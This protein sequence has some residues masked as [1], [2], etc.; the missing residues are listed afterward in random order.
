MKRRFLAWLLCA[1]MLFNNALPVFA[2]EATEHVHSEECGHV[3]CETCGLYDCEGHT[4]CTICGAL[5]CEK[6]HV[7][8]S[9]C[10]EYD[11]VKEHK[12]CEICSTVDCTADHAYCEACEKYDCGETHQAEPTTC[13]DCDAEL[14]EGET[15]T[16]PP[17]CNCGETHDETN[18]DCPLYVAPKTHKEGCTLDADHEGDC[19]VAPANTCLDCKA[20]IAE[21]EEHE[22]ELVGPPKCCDY[23]EV[24][25]NG[26]PVHVGNCPNITPCG[27]CGQLGHDEN[28]CH[29]CLAC[30]EKA[31]EH[32][33]DA[34]CTYKCEICGEKHENCPECKSC[35]NVEG[36]AHTFGE[37]CKACPACEGVE[38]AEHKTGC[39]NAPVLCELCGSKVK[40]VHNEMCP[41]LC[42]CEAEEGAEHAETC[43]LYVEKKW[44]S[45]DYNAETFEHATDC[46][47]CLGCR[48]ESEE[49]SADKNCKFKCLGCGNIILDAEADHK[50]D[51]VFCIANI[52]EPVEET[53][54]D[55][56]DYTCPS[57]FINAA[58]LIPRPKRE[59]ATFN[60]LKGNAPKDNENVITTKTVTN[61][62]NGQ[63]TLTLESYIE[64]KTSTEN[65]P[66][67]VVLVLD[68]S[69]SMRSCYECGIVACK[70]N[71]LGQMIVSSVNN[72]S[73]K[74]EYHMWTIV[75]RNG[76]NASGIPTYANTNL[77]DRY[78]YNEGF[79]KSG[80]SLENK[81]KNDGTVYYFYNPYGAEGYG[82]VYL[83]NYCTKCNNWVKYKEHIQGV[84]A[85]QC[86]GGQL[87][88]GTTSEDGYWGTFM[89]Y[90]PDER[91][92][93]PR[94]DALK[95]AVNEF[96]GKV[97]ED[98]QDR[99][100]ENNVAIVGFAAETINTGVIAPLGRLYTEDE[101]DNFIIQMENLEAKGITRT[102]LGMKEASKILNSN[103]IKY[104][105][106]NKVVIVF[107]DGEPTIESNGP[108][109]IAPGDQ[110]VS[111]FNKYTANNALAEAQT[112]KRYATI[113]TIGIFSGD[114]GDREK[115]LPEYNDWTWDQYVGQNDARQDATN[116]FC[117]LLSSNYL[118][119]TDMINTGEENPSLEES[120]AGYFISPDD[121]ETLVDA[122]NRIAN[123]LQEDASLAK[124]DSTTKVTDIVSP[125]F[126]VDVDAV[127]TREITAHTESYTE[128][129]WIDNDDEG[130]FTDYIVQSGN[131]ISVSNFNFY[132]NRVG[133]ETTTDIG[134]TITKRYFGK[135]LVIEIPIKVK[136]DFL[137]GNGVLTNDFA[138]GI[139]TS[140]G[141][142]IENFE[143][144]TVNI[145]VKE[146]V[147]TF[148]TGNIY[149][150]QYA[151]VSHIANVGHFSYSDDGETVYTTVDGINNAYVDIEY[152]ITDSEGNSIIYLLEDKTSHSDHGIDNWVRGVGNLDM[153]PFLTGDTTYKVKAVV[154]PI[155][156]TS[157]A[158]G[159]NDPI[160]VANPSDEIEKQILVYKPHITF[161]DSAMDL[162]ETADYATNNQVINN[163]EDDA[164]YGTNIVWKNGSDLA[165]PT[166]MGPAPILTYTYDPVAADFRAET[167]VK[168]TEIY[169][170]AANG[171]DGNYGHDVKEDENLLPYVTFYREA[172]EFKGCGHSD[173][174][175]F[176]SSSD[177]PNF[178]VHLNPFD[179][180]IKKN[181]ADPIDE[182]QSF[183][184]RVEGNGM[185][186]DVIVQGN[187]SA[188]VVSLPVGD[189]EY[190]VT[191]LIDWSWRYEVANSGSVTQ[192]VDLRNYKAADGP[193]TI[194]FNNTR[195]NILWLD[196][197]C[198][199]ENLW[200]GTSSISKKEEY[201]DPTKS[202]NQ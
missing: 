52:E 11:C 28:N 5:D 107:T 186:L 139:Y 137:G 154:T 119:A 153:N 22:C 200:T 46:Q 89:A 27:T 155:H 110:I 158:A 31:D 198:Y 127:N 14:V 84:T 193:A 43:P 171:Y 187:N 104:N 181:G 24:D 21:G 138:S 74:K 174:A 7:K 170:A 78:N 163:T 42:N 58:G 101:L 3:P 82:D 195:N 156:V 125:S 151:T 199:C 26:M 38:D 190:T 32:T 102:D 53:Q 182:N 39:E 69:G 180:I 47:E 113:Y 112:I 41:T 185:V 164:G 118:K 106:H 152:T 121:Y 168:V 90:D 77:K 18:A 36:E 169:A 184:F 13:P 94:R 16:C 30:L 35:W 62:G 167:P 131:E 50:E 143:Q 117:H 159:N 144:P 17:S 126:I 122:F 91:N 160:Y 56:M 100:V 51:C 123:N 175:P 67:D 9:I 12:E 88:T 120:D 10:N 63:Y 116:R 66:V 162:G 59:K 29:A 6:E 189:G 97:L 114:E 8:C 65:L 145:P 64:A 178:Y 71:A 135:K 105:N 192:N 183:I 55:D 72:S 2:T 33:F 57:G 157:D 176:T 173:E 109:P 44:C 172:C 194:T 34:Y 128:N 70:H 147:P 98:S 45:C 92:H 68:Q 108:D 76:T 136:P 142:L 95:Y 188:K 111:Y 19:V 149:L 87:E 196:G 197:D 81:I 146:I 85:S 191:E 37:N 79:S 150:S 80:S 148:K 15:H 179:L 48:G 20:E 49:H 86:N 134:G 201:T 40:D 54:T 75:D 73:T 25:E 61:N 141:T 4:T 165:N 166:E 130:S 1:V 202:T 60:L 23:T 124:L 96:L 132:E 93:I 133:V 83:V 99:N 161:K 129:K 115:G 177:K 103:A 140:D